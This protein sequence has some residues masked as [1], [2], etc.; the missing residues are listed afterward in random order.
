MFITI[1]I[2]NYNIIIIAIHSVAMSPQAIPLQAMEGRGAA[3][4]A[5]AAGGFS[6]ATSARP[7]PE[8]MGGPS[9][10]ASIARRSTNSPTAGRG[11]RGLRARVYSSR[12]R[13][14]SPTRVPVLLRRQLTRVS[15]PLLWPSEAVSRRLM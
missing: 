14:T 10:P 1:I 7:R 8:E 2:I 12:A 9:G 11:R 3:A 13:L 15:M 5:A 4:S 6:A